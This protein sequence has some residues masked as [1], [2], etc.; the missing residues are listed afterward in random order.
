MQIFILIYSFISMN[1]YLCKRYDIINRSV[2]TLWYTLYSL[3]RECRDVLVVFI[4]IIFSHG[5]VF[6]SNIKLLW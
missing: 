5:D 6:D 1:W 2:W 4:E 3:C